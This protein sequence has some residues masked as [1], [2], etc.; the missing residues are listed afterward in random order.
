MGKVAILISD[1]HMGRGDELEDFAPENEAALVRFL[2]GQSDEHQGDEV[3]LV[4]LGDAMDLWQVVAEAEKTAARSSDIPIDY[5]PAG[6]VARVEQIVAAHPSAWNALHDFLA[7]GAAPRRLIIIPGNHDHAL[8]NEQ[9]QQAVRVAVAAGSA[10]LGARVSFPYYYDQPA[11]RAYAEHGCQYDDNNSYGDFG[12]YLTETPGYFVV[13][14]FWNRLE[15]RLPNADDWWNSFRAIVRNKLWEQW[16]PAIRLFQQYR[17]DQRAFPRIGIGGIT[18]AADAAL[19][20]GPLAGASLPDWPDVLLG[21][22]QCQG[23]LFST[24]ANTE[25]LLRDLYHSPDNAE[26]RQSV[27]EVLKAR[28]GAAPPAVPSDHVAVVA[29]FGLFQDQY[30]GAATGMFARGGRPARTRL[31]RGRGLAERAYDY[32]L[33]GHT[34]DEKKVQLGRPNAFYLNTGAW[35]ARRDERARNVAHLCY[36]KLQQQDDG[37][38]LTQALWP[39]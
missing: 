36:V 18:F 32:V 6:D 21:S 11:L 29:E 38:A 19:A 34:H 27:D 31:L 16:G 30:V 10:G 9:V 23:R 8:V 24:E 7:A 35:V 2:A 17:E 1:L 39:L 26:F 4:L 5:A 13:R 37:V 3:D 25:N 15:A 20:G 14:L 28:F 12:D 33:L 22:A